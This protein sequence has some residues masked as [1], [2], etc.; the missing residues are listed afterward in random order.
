[1]ACHSISMPRAGPW[2]QAGC[3]SQ[4]PRAVDYWSCGS[5][6]TAEDVASC[7]SAKP[8]ALTLKHKRYLV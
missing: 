2:G 8:E 3:L 5:E 4:A 1:M 6:L 7:W